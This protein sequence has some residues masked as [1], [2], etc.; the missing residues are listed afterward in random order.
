MDPP[1][2]HPQ[3]PGVAHRLHSCPVDLVQGPTD[4]STAPLEILVRVR[5]APVAWAP[6]APPLCQVVVL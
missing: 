5:L 1:P 4:L 6:V 3:H 2:G